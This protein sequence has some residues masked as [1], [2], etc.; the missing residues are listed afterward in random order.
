MSLVERCTHR[1][2]PEGVAGYSQEKQRMPT[3]QSRLGEPE[4]ISEYRA[5]GGSSR[6]GRLWNQI[7][8]VAKP[9][10]TNDLYLS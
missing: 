4:T 9:A 8:G 7:W 10:E 1:H 6:I 2:N 3:M 5:S